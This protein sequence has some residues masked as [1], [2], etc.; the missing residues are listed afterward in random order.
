MLVSFLH[1]FQDVTLTFNI[2]NSV[3]IKNIKSWYHETTHW[4]ESY[5][6]PHEYIFFIYKWE[7]SVKDFKVWPTKNEVGTILWDEGSAIYETTETFYRKL[8][9]QHPYCSF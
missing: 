7:Y 2:F 5:K 4:D 8:D 3:L 1:G 6:I 9:L